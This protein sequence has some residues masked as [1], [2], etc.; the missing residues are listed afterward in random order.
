MLE[1]KKKI[2]NKDSTLKNNLIQYLNINN[3]YFIIFNTIVSINNF[4]IFFKKSKNI[5]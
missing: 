5:L 1:I 3:N 4:K 2:K